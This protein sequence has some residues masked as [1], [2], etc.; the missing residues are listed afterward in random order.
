VFPLLLTLLSGAPQRPSDELVIPQLRGGGQQVTVKVLGG[1]YKLERQRVGEQT[2][3]A[4]H[5]E[6]LVTLRF[7]LSGTIPIQSE[8]KTLTEGGLVLIDEAGQSHEPVRNFPLAVLQSANQAQESG[9][10]LSPAGQFSFGRGTLSPIFQAVFSVPAESVIAD[11]G[12][13]TGARAPRLSL[14]NK[15]AGLDYYRASTFVPLQDINASRGEWYMGRALD[16]KMLGHE[17]KTGMLGE[18]DGAEEGEKFEIVSFSVKNSSARPLKLYDDAASKPVFALRL[19]N[20]RIKREEYGALL[21]DSDN[22]LSDFDIESGSELKFRLAFKL[23][24][25]E[26][27]KEIFVIDSAGGLRARPITWPWDGRGTTPWQKAAD[28]L[29]P[30]EPSEVLMD[31]QILKGIPVLPSQLKKKYPALFTTAEAAGKFPKITDTLHPLNRSFMLPMKEIVVGPTVEG[32][33]FPQGVFSGKSSGATVKIKA[34]NDSIIAGTLKAKGVNGSSISAFVKG[35]KK[36]ATIKVKSG[37]AYTA[38][39]SISVGTK[40]GIYFAEFE[41]STGKTRM[42]VPVRFIIEAVQYS[43]AISPQAG[44]G[45]YMQADSTETISPLVHLKGNNPLKVKVYAE[46][47]S[48]GVTCDPVEVTLQ[49]NQTT[50][51][52]LTFAVAANAKETIINKHYSRLCIESTSPAMKSAFNYQIMVEANWVVFTYSGTIGKVKYVGEVLVTGNGDWLWSSNGTTGS[53]VIGDTLI[54][55]LLF[56]HPDAEGYRR[57][58]QLM[59]TLNAKA[60]SGPDLPAYKFGG[61]D[62]WL[63][64][65]FYQVADGG[66]SV[67]LLRYDNGIFAFSP[68]AP[69][70]FDGGA[71]ADF[72]KWLNAKKAK[73]MIKPG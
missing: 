29:A 43:L 12:F 30:T 63:S 40:P 21:P 27:P 15:L 68:T 31:E 67:R 9:R 64:D 58:S 65:N 32:K 45:L 60:Q 37:T 62:K 71:P 57:Y 28:S 8:G 66:I 42:L 33:I 50:E 23:S 56:N 19:T 53:V 47:L 14:K 2:A 34:L 46:N 18:I 22:G 52:P 10:S 39:F 36:E 26:V 35:S 20:G 44:S 61:N 59:L 41:I 48:A 1:E 7:Q 11:L 55:A 25:S 51:V 49:P 4:N 6:K 54:Q 69:W 5:N 73:Y 13:G 38:N 70:E 16:F 72:I 17:S 3:Y 24:N